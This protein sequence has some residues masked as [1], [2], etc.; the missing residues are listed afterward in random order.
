MARKRTETYTDVL[1]TWAL[2][3]I[4]NGDA[5]TLTDDEMEAVDKYLGWWELESKRKGAVSY[6]ISP[7]GEEYFSDYNSITNYEGGNVVDALVTLLF[8]E[9][10]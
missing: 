2:P 10:E 7:D 9:E 3:Y 8:D 1:P 5:D 4:I 6:T